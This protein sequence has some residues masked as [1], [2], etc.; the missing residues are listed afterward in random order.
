MELSSNLSNGKEKIKSDKAAKSACDES[1]KGFNK[2]LKKVG[3]SR[4]GIIDWLEPK[5]WRQGVAYAFFNV[6]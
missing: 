3:E 5:C 1:Q 2:K 4:D 6:G